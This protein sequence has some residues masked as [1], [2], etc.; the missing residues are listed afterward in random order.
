MTPQN[1]MHGNL[2]DMS[3]D[4]LQYAL[5]YCDGEVRRAATNGPKLD[6]YER[7]RLDVEREIGWRRRRV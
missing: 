1:A 7:R 2:Y 5:A 4:E 3:I 6:L